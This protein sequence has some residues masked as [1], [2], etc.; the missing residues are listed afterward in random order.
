MK[1]GMSIFIFKIQA[2]LY[3]RYK[4]RSCQGACYIV[5][6]SKTVERF[7]QPD[8]SFFFQFNLGVVQFFGLL[9]QVFAELR[10]RHVDQCLCALVNGLSIQVSHTMLSNH[11]ADMISTG[12]HSGARF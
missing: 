10:M 1:T 2:G 11:I 3:N 4:S 5:K 6:L 12:D 8:D 7:P 9:L